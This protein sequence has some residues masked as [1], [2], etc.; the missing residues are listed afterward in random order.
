MTAGYRL[1]FDRAGEHLLQRES[2]VSDWF[3]GKNHRLIHEADPQCTDRINVR[4]VFLQS[5][6]TDRWSITIGEILY[7]LRSCLDHIAFELNGRP[8][9]AHYLSEFP[10]VGREN[11]FGK[12]DT[13][14]NDAPR[15]FAE[16]VNR[17]LVGCKQPAV[18]AIEAMQPYKHALGYKEH[19]L[20][21]LNFLCNMDKHRTLHVVTGVFEG[22]S[23]DAAMYPPP[24]TTGPVRQHMGSLEADTILLSYTPADQQNEMDIGFMPYFG[25]GITNWYGGHRSITGLLT[26]IRVFVCNNVIYPLSLLT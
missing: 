2:E 10:I 19:P 14:P 4:V 17:K 3:N 26:C 18:E 20:W 15:K 7:N 22:F 23:D 21:M 24:K 11:Q 1:K 16:F 12:P 5:P 9:N 6:P 25:I 13:N 8:H